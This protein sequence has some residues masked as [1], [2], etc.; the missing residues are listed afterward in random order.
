MAGVLLF[1]ASLAFAKNINF[2]IVQNSCAADEIF[3]ISD[4]FEQAVADFFFEAGH[5]VSNEPVCLK[6]SGGD[7][8]AELKRNLSDSVLGGM[9][10]FVSIEILFDGEK[11]KNPK[12]LDLNSINEVEWKIYDV[13]TGKLLAA[14]EISPDKKKNLKK[15]ESEIYTFASFAASKISSGLKD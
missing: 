2:Q 12:T 10:F 1:F 11:G 5:I 15:N 3:A 4:L 14:S 8:K 7:D 9:D 13:K 6:D